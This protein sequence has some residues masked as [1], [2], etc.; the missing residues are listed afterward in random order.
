VI[1]A[2]YRRWLPET[3][4]FEIRREELVRLGTRT[5]AI[6]ETLGLLARQYPARLTCMLIAVAAFD[7][8]MAPSVILMAKYLQQDHHYAPGQVTILYVFGGFLSV[9]GNILMGRISDRIGRKVVIVLCGALCAGS[10]AVFFS[11]IGG[12]QLPAAWIAA[13]FGYLSATALTAGFVA[14]IFPTA[15]RATTSTLRYVVTTLGGATALALEGPLYNVFHAHGPAISSFLAI[16]PLS[17]IAIL[18]LPE[19]AGRPLEEIA[20]TPPLPL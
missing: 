5:H 7:F 10:F 11:G 18:L 1:L 12:W 13:I 14:E 4:R 20:V 15:Y 8:A 3:R 17:L 19:S 16:M 6:W 2:W 9:V